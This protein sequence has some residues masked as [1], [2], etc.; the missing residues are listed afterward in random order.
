M[1]SGDQAYRIQSEEVQALRLAD[2]LSGVRD[3]LNRSFRDAI[4]I[5]AEVNSINANRQSGHYYLELVENEAGTI[6]AKTNATLFQ[7]VARRVLGRFQ[8]VTGSTIQTGMQL[9]LLVRVEYTPRW[10]FSLN[11]LDINPEYTLGQHERV[12]QET[13]R[14]LQ[15]EGVWDLNKS[16]VLPLLVQR[17]AVIS[18][19]TAAGWGDFRR[20]IE[21]SL[22]AGFIKIDLFPALMQGQSASASICSALLAIYNRISEYDAVV[23]IRGGGSKLDLAAFDDY[24]LCCYIANFPAPIITGIGHERDESVADMIAHTGLKTPT[25]VADFLIRRMEQVVQRLFQSEERVERLLSNLI[26]SNQ[27]CLDKLAR[28]SAGVLSSLEKQALIQ[29]NGFKSV[30]QEYLRVMLVKYLN[31]QANI[32]DRAT[33]MLSGVERNLDLSK[34]ELRLVHL[35]GGV[36]NRVDRSEQVL[37]LS[38]RRLERTLQALPKELEKTQD[39]YEQLIRIQDP[40]NI[41]RRGFLPVV[42]EQGTSVIS[43]KDVRVDERLRIIMPDGEVIAGIDHIIHNE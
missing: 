41:M 34:V 27:E 18:S 29:L 40:R 1:Y 30:L 17:V 42:N 43:V 4:W 15:S 16:H 37:D 38:A 22:V 7:N 31:R 5:I 26:I 14:R 23:I 24:A 25:A 36:R 33:R 20:Q 11:I 32:Q 39:R 21:Q 8:E 9:M 12:K 19:E 3:L 35:L 28:R 6:L 2:L 13:I 10:G